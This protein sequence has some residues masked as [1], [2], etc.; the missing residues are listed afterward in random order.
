MNFKK[1]DDV[2]LN[3]IEGTT[4]IKKS[5]K[6]KRK[7]NFENKVKKKPLQIKDDKK[8]PDNQNTQENKNKNKA[9]M[10]LEKASNKLKKGNI[11]IDKK[12]DFHGLS[13]VDA[14][15]LLISTINHCFQDNKRCILFITGKGS[16][17]KEKE[18]DQTRLFFGKIRGSFLDWTKLDDV[19]NKILQVHKSA[20]KH[21]G[22]GAFYVYLRKNKN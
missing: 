4:P 11:K 17:L 2:F 5:N 19:K 8:N 14:K 20:P 16:S 12:I 7:I 18:T 3:Y 9:H 1:E 10:G 13:L 6:V 15:K 22:D 21:G